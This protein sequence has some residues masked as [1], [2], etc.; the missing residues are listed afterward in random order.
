MSHF[1]LVL[2]LNAAESILIDT[3][4]WDKQKK[5]EGK[6]GGKK[7]GGGNPKLEINGA[8]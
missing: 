2:L 5:K 8:E 3:P 7:E 1:D 4:P 6:E